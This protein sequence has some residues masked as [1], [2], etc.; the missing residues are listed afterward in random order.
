MG[1]RLSL[2]SKGLREVGGK[3]CCPGDALRAVPTAVRPPGG[4]GGTQ[5]GSP[6]P[7]FPG[8]LHARQPGPGRLT[9]P[10]CTSSS[11]TA[12]LFSPWAILGHR[13]NSSS[14]CVSPR[15]SPLGAGLCTQRVAMFFQVSQQHGREVW[16]PSAPWFPR[17]ERGTVTA[18]SLEGGGEG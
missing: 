1:R 11:K 2:S 16:S 9:L 17:L 7:P 8:Q 14:N 10:A 12:R 3:R 6:K 15:S 18:P 5:A 4:L 13:E